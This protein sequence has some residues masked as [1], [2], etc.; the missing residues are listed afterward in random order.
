MLKV[1]VRKQIRSEA[2]KNKVNNNQKSIKHINK[3]S[4]C[5]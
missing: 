4:K 5:K 1:K 2:N 3:L